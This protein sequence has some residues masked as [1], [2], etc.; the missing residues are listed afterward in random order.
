MYTTQSSPQPIDREQVRQQLKALGY[1]AGDTVY[2]RAFY[3]DSDP[4]KPNDG[5]RKAVATKLDE[6]IKHATAF[7]AEG[8]GVYFVVNGG[9]QKKEDVHHGRAIFY[10]HDNLDKATQTDLWKSLRLPEPTFQVD[11]G[12]KS[13]HSYWV[14]DEHIGIGDWQKLQADLLEFADADRS[15][16]DPSRVMRL[17]GA[18]HSSGNQSLIISNSG[19]RYKYSDLREIV[20]APKAETPLFQAKQPRN[21]PDSSGTVPKKYEDIVLPVPASIPLEACLAV[22]SRDLLNGVSEGG[23]N[24]A[25]YILA[26]DLIGATNYLQAIGQSFEGDAESL[27]Q[28][29]GDRCNPPLNAGEL[30]SIWKSAQGSNP[31]P[32][33]K[34]EG[35]ENCIKGHYWNSIR[36]ATATNQSYGRAAAYA[37]P[38]KLS[39]KEAVALARATL[40]AATDEISVN[41]E[42][43]EIREKTGMSEYSWEHKIIKPLRR[44]MDAERFKLELLGLLQ[45]EDKV[46]Q[47]RQIALLAPKYSMGAGTIEKA[48]AAMKSRTQTAEIQGSMSLEE[49]FAKT[50][51]AMEWLVPGMLPVGETV[52]LTALPKTGKS[53]LAIDLA[54]CVATGEEKFLGEE[55]KQGRVLLVCPDAS[56]RSLKNEL[57]RRGFRIQKDSQNLRVMSRWSIDQISVLEKELE[58]FRPDFVVIDS[59]KAITSGK[60]IS[61]NS[62]EFADN[63]ITLNSLLTRYSAASLL[64]HHANKGS[65]ASGVERARG[66]TAIVGACWGMWLMEPIPQ[67]DRDNPKRMIIDP[68]DP[69][70]KFHV[71]SR[72]SEGTILNIQFNAENN[73]WISSGEFEIEKGEAQR[74]QSI[75]ERLMN[76]FRSNPDKELSGPEIMELLGGI[77]KD[78]RGAYYNALNRM[79]NKRIISVRPASGDKRYN[80]YSLPSSNKLP[81]TGA[82]PEKQKNSLPPPP[83]TPTV[84][85]DD[86]YPE[87]L[88][89]QGLENSHHNSHQIVINS[90]EC[91]SCE[92]AETLTEHGL[93]K[94][95]INSQ[96]SQ[97]GGGVKCASIYSE[98]QPSEQVLIAPLES[99][100]TESPSVPMVNWNVGD[101]VKVSAEYVTH[102]YRGER[103]TVIKVWS[104]GL[105]RIE[106]DR[107]ISVIEGKPKKQFNLNGRYLVVSDLK[108]EPTAQSVPPIAPPEPSPEPESIAPAP[109]PDPELVEQIVAKVQKAIAENDP[110]AARKVAAPTNIKLDPTSRLKT[111]VK[112]SLTDEENA[113]FG[114]LLK[115]RQS[116]SQPIEPPVA[117]ARAATPTES[118]SQIPS[119]PHAPPGPPSKHKNFAVGDRVVVARD[120]RSMY[121]GAKGKVIK[122][123]GQQVSI[124][125]DKAVRGN[126]SATFNL[127]STT[128][129]K[130]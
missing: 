60:E 111:A 7:Q 126:N 43:E 75:N 115:V 66:S 81:S 68:R 77:E 72:D 85:N 120:D 24:K 99:K 63:I 82:M 2:L 86:Y 90:N 12:G 108:V 29:F 1:E 5:G 84:S 109:E 3:P 103:A 98:A 50:S 9:G 114:I 61:E 95:V 65:E 37:K 27:F 54:F 107:E 123:N 16:K 57:T 59:L 94:I 31:S 4:R 38:Q 118:E 116:Q 51:E 44:E 78:Q 22:A 48:M 64:I 76:I 47:Y 34:A 106:L 10:E 69:N 36:P 96:L 6:L 25:G 87:P 62:A 125:F 92:N 88:M 55:V 102:E 49:L 91:A 58:D 32:A 8:R 33:C 121:E 71:T 41:L 67:P 117:S 28:D 45:M 110:A 83:P 13:I 104:D 14:F 30:Q 101:R 52:L 70:R 21:N 105:C 127:A 42:L 74:Q 18:W 128:L 73:S 17:A 23:R 40:K 129:M 97:G 19:K 112:N 113:A 93:D 122:V 39:R 53:K 124:E 11:T 35:V 80:L 26:C 119:E 89:E 46:E 15:I 79:E 130:L 56:E 100:P 20:P